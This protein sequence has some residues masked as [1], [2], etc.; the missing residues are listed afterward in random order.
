MCGNVA[1][2]AFATQSEQIARWMPSVLEYLHRF[3]GP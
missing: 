3:G 1:H 2:A